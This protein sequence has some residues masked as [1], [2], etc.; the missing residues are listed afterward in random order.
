MARLFD[1]ARDTAAGCGRDPAD[2]EM[3]AVHLGL[4][5]DDPAAAVQEAESWGVARLMVPSVFYF[6]NTAE[7]LAAFGESVI[8][9]HS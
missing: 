2:L 4:F 8:A 6:R 7:A 9:T 1:L 5:G 3:S